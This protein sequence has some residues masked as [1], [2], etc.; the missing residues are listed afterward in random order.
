[1]HKKYPIGWDAIPAY[2]VFLVDHVFNN[3]EQ[4]CK[5][6]NYPEKMPYTCP[7]FSIWRVHTLDSSPESRHGWVS[8]PAQF[9]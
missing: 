9:A 2:W 3:P 4:P 7:V 8:S 1:M 6:M 5:Q